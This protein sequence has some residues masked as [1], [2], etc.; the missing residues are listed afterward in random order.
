MPA[1]VLSAP[2]DR[3][4]VNLFSPTGKDRLGHRKVSFRNRFG[5][6]TTVNMLRKFDHITARIFVI[7]LIGLL[8]LRAALAAAP[9]FHRQPIFPPEP[10]HN[11]ASCLL[12]T[13]KGYFLAAW[14]SGSG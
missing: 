6:R 10:K 7:M 1:R 3:L 11:H 5:R 4:P 12:A 9:E 13:G 14:Y 2:G 8:C